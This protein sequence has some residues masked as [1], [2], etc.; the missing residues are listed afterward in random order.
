MIVPTIGRETLVRTVESCRG[1]TEI[2]VVPDG[3]DAHT[4]AQDLLPANGLPVRIL[5]PDTDVRMGEYGHPQRNKG[6]AE[7]K[8]GWL[9]FL[10][11]D[12]V[13]VPGAISFVNARLTTRR[14]HIFRM[15]YG[16][17]S[18]EHG[19][20]LWGEPELHSCNVGTPMFVIPNKTLPEWRPNPGVQDGRS[21]DFLFITE[22]CELQGKPVFVDKVIA[23][24]R[25]SQQ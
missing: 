5:E 18:P 4:A 6:M 9:M 15:H 22:A 19:L 12:D 7:A 8:G 23:E 11:D 20:T 2:L 16:E 17:G 1:A 25:P 24:V 10:D 14:P 3:R 21:G 13:F